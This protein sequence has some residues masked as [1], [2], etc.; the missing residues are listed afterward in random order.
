M[1]KI[2]TENEAASIGNGLSASN[3]CCTKTRAEELGCSV[4]GTYT[5]N[6]LVQKDDLSSAALNSG[7]SI[8]WEEGVIG[9]NQSVIVKRAT[10]SMAFNYKLTKNSFTTCFAGI[11]KLKTGDTLYIVG[12]QTSRSTFTIE[13]TVVENMNYYWKNQINNQ[14]GYNSIG[15][16]RVGG[17]YIITCTKEMTPYHFANERITIK[18][19][20]DSSK[21]VTVCIDIQM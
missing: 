1:G 4:S 9:L 12:T 15:T 18:D 17:N 10:G 16:S 7:V 20:D 19:L 2:A 3:K 11:D 21:S 8:K 5:S 6:Q 14:G 13:N